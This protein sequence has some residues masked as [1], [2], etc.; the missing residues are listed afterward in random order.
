M[1]LNVVLNT[2]KCEYKLKMW[3]VV[4]KTKEWNGWGNT[5]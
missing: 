4:S 3:Q 1:F 5:N 2:Q